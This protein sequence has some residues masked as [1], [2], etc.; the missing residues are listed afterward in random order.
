MGTKRKRG[1]CE[2][3]ALA[4]VGRG[5]IEDAVVA[6]KA[7]LPTKAPETGKDGAPQEVRRAA[8]DDDEVVEEERERIGEVFAVH[9]YVA[10]LALCAGG[11]RSAMS[12]ADVALEG[13]KAW[14]DAR[15]GRQIVQEEGRAAAAGATYDLDGGRAVLDRM[16]EVGLTSVANGSTEAVT[17]SRIRLSILSGDVDSAVALLRTMKGIR[18]PTLSVETTAG[19]SGADEG[20][21]RRDQ[22]NDDKNTV[23]M[24]RMKSRSVSPVIH[25][26]CLRGLYSD[27]V[28]ILGE[29]MEQRE[30]DN[31]K[32]S[33]DDIG[34]T[35]RAMAGAVTISDESREQRRKMCES[36]VQWLIQGFTELP[37]WEVADSIA[38]SLQRIGF[39]GPVP[40]VSS[41]CANATV[42]RSADEGPH[43]SASSVSKVVVDD[44]GCLR[45][46]QDNCVTDSKGARLFM[47][48]TPL[49]KE[50][51][52]SF[53]LSVRR[54]ATERAANGKQDFEA[55]VQWLERTGPYEWVLDGANIA[56]F[57]QS[58]SK[59][60]SFQQLDAAY[61]E[62]RR[63]SGED[64]AAASTGEGAERVKPPLIIL[65]ENRLRSPEAKRS[66]RLI[67]SWRDSGSIYATPT[68]SNDDWYW[69]YAAVMAGDGARLVSNDEL[70]DHSF[71]MLGG[72]Y[73]AAWKERH[74]VAFDFADGDRNGPLSFQMPSRFTTCIQ[75]LEDG[76]W[77][78]PVA[79]S[80]CWL[81]MRAPSASST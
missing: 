30:D 73:I 61:R 58:T 46:E 4:A 27:A 65:H 67:Q 71:Q 51:D 39:F 6:L 16:R 63:R 19:R 48:T 60:F 34:A 49:P 14:E 11:G 8:G 68:G 38:A 26:L 17:T 22:Q 18:M 77:I 42:T 12:A 56:L 2:Q 1:S 31:L 78:F 44:E 79:N 32:P 3:R 66:S 24:A 69:I 43:L 54:I 36:V 20:V 64:C 72:K 7:S 37:S 52:A 76:S 35:L 75:K 28:C 62:A 55:F 59:S 57:G 47:R 50:D 45:D 70:R 80:K 40:A 33:V 15:A 23:S 74:R 29:L 25:A 81:H 10:L 53:Q 41:A 13:H 5:D 21:G 9:S